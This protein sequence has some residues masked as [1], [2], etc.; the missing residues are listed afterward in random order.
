[1]VSHTWSESLLQSFG[2]F[3][4]SIFRLFFTRWRYNSNTL[5]T[6]PQEL[7]LNWT[8]NTQ[9][10][11]K[12]VKLWD[13]NF[14]TLL[15]RL[16][17]ANFILGIFILVIWGPLGRCEFSEC[18]PHGPKDCKQQ[19]DSAILIWPPPLWSSPVPVPRKDD[20]SPAFVR[21]HSAGSLHPRPPCPSPLRKWKECLRRRR[22]LRGLECFCES[23]CWPW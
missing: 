4:I 6:G 23:I 9:S 8:E 11:E 10:P 19:S 7:G 14:F 15:E 16:A 18:W 5:N 12:C 3:S 17:W 13:Y 21:S 22:A 1:M 20:H 2:K